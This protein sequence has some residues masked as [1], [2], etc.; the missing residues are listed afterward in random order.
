MRVLSIFL[1]VMTALPAMADI[2]VSKRTIRAKEVVS[3]ADLEIKDQ[4]VPN[5]VTSPE[6]LIGQEA[7]VALYPGRPIR[8]GDVGPPAIVDRNDLV[9]LVFDRRPLSI[10]AEGRAL[11]RGAAGDRIRVM[12][13]S[14]RTTITGFI[15][16]DGQIEVK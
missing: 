14:S 5:A 1:T 13:L 15:R 12:N 7:R 10:T 9:V 3:A 8:E 2:V 11:G 6:A 4:V 16:P